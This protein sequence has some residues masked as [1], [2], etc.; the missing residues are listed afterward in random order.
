[1]K[2]YTKGGDKG[3]TSLIGGD[4][5]LKSHSRI[6]AYGTVDELN[7]IIGIVRD[8][9]NDKDSDAELQSIQ[10]VLFS[11]GSALAAADG[12]K[13]QLPEFDETDIKALEDSIDK[14]NEEL[15]DL[16]NFILPG[17]DWLLHIVI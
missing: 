2:I 7:A 10:N 14:M 6:E 15:P 5:V 9:A 17:G 1:M 13:M 16:R 3:E 4:R 11:I 12:H 8:S